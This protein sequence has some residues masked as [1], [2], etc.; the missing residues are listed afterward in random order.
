MSIDVQQLEAN[1]QQ[2]NN[3]TGASRSPGMFGNMVSNYIALKTT[4][5]GVEVNTVLGGIQS[6]TQE[7]DNIAPGITQHMSGVPIAQLTSELQGLQ[8]K[9]VVPLSESN[10]SDMAAITGTATTADPAMLDVVVTAGTPD[11]VAAA[12]KAA[13]PTASSSE[14]MGVL[15]QIQQPLSFGDLDFVTTL[16]D[17]IKPVLD[18]VNNL[19]SG[20]TDFLGGVDE[21]LSKVGVSSSF[22]SEIT[23]AINNFQSGILD[24]INLSLPTGALFSSITSSNEWTSLSGITP[25]EVGATR[26]ATPSYQP[27]HTQEELEYDLRSAS[28][29]ITELVVHWT[30]TSYDQN[31][32]P[33]L[34]SS[35]SSNTSYHY[36]INRD[37]SIS[38]GLSLDAV[39]G[40]LANG[41][42][43]YS[44]QIAFMGGLSTPQTVTENQTA[45]SDSLTP[46][47]MKSFQTFVGK[48]FLAWPGLQ[49]LG[50]SDIDRSQQDP[51]F[52]VPGLIEKKF[53]KRNVFTDAYSQAPFTRQELVNM[54]LP[55]GPL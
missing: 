31:I 9:L 38:R 11:A 24:K 2:I 22:S 23:S 10:Q 26:N 6:L 39:G 41:H 30:G 52:D 49:V 18:A 48:A 16:D 5:L 55:Q 7:L 54:K 44:I 35:L 34:F 19:T 13:V 51:G 36:Y 33:G 27:I 37:G 50:H 15:N 25:R 17:A 1:L 32:S 20:L 21:A 42:E 45:S 40:T 8:S 46:E 12:V 47:Q 53:G 43:K 3:T 4:A 28:R 29:E 14:V